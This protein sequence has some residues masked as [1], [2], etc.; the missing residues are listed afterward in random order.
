MRA[1]EA[2]LEYINPFEQSNWDEMVEAHPA[3]SIFHTTMWARVLEEAY[4]YRPVYFAVVENGALRALLPMME[5]N[6]LL[7]GKRGVSLPFSDYADPFGEDEE[8]YRSLVEKAVRYGRD[9][10]WKTVEIRGGM[11]PW[12]DSPPSVEFLGHKL[13]LTRPEKDIYDSF[14]KNMKRNISRSLKEGVSVEISNSAESMEEYYKLHCITRQGHGIPPQPIKFFRK[15]REHVLQGNRGFVVLSKF[16][17]NIVAGAVY[18][19]YG[20]K[21]I[22]KYGAS[23]PDGKESR[24]NNLVMWEAIRWYQ[25][26]GFEEFCFGRTEQ[27]NEGL[28]E[29]KSGYGTTEFLLPYYKLDISGNRV[30]KIDSGGVVGRLQTYYSKVPIPVSRIIGTCLYRH[31]G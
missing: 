19:H 15:I 21:A 10:G 28:R 22:Y 3:G 12:M 25:Q 4:G 16:Q 13:D 29:Y 24:A 17:G 5:I 18:F 9:A 8:Q 27:E 11:K 6:S 23:N 14:R 20:K 26:N 30:V 31:I 7:T 2:A 1:G